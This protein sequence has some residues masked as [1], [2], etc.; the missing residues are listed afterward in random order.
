MGLRDQVLIVMVGVI[1]LM[2]IMRAQWGLMGYVWFGLMRPDIMAYSGYNRYSLFIAVS[3]LIGTIPRLPQLWLIFQNPYSL[4]YVVF[5]IP[6]FLSV[7][8]AVNP[9]WSIPKYLPFL[10]MSLM[11]LLQPLLLSKWDELKQFYLVMAF[12]IGCVGL[13][14]GL[15]GLLAGGVRYEQGLG[16]FHAD[17]NTLALGLVMGLPLTWYAISMVRFWP[18]KALFL[19]LSFGSLATIVMTQSRGGLIALAIVLVLIAWNSKQRA[20]VFLALVLL[21]LPVAMLVGPAV[22]ERMSTLQD[23]MEDGSARLRWDL[24]KAALKMIPEYFFFGVGFGAD[25]FANLSGPYTEYGNITKHVVHNNY[26]QMFVDSGVFAFLIF[27]WLLFGSS[28]YAWRQFRR[29]QET[30][31]EWSAMAGGLSVSLCGFAVGSLFG[32]RT[33]YDFIYMLIVTVGCL[34]HVIRH[35]DPQPVTILDTAGLVSAEQV[36]AQPEPMAGAKAPAAPQSPR[37]GLGRALRNAG[38]GLNVP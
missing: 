29:F 7:A 37:G 38:R 33:N 4:G 21:T 32:S 2:G 22:V 6:I 36:A 12:A 30:R 31:P 1:C 5:Q 26:L 14:Y 15:W 25:N 18:L 34:H 11:V 20:K 19:G 17:N 9:D 24:N 23:P 3:T 10:Q 13:K 28:F 35:P 16:G 8:M 27:C